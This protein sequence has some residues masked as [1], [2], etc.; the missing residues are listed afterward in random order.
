MANVK[1]YIDYWNLQLAWN[2]HMSPNKP[3]P[4]NPAIR[5]A[6]QN[7]PTV[8]LSE[9]PKIFGPGM[10][11]TH[12]GTQV[13]A[14][15]QPQGHAGK[16]PAAF[17]TWLRS[18][19]GQMTGFRISV[20][21]RKPKK[22]DCPLCKKPIHRTVEKGVDTS[23]VTDLFAGALNDSYDIAILFSNDS[24]F[25]PAIATIQDRLNKQIIHAGFNM[26]ADAVRT[27]AWGHIV[28]DGTVADSL[29]QAAV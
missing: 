6:W 27:A 17:R 9:L 3:T 22:D 28:L 5:L 10:P 1:I 24:D 26:G 23:I 4:E 21:E 13:Y 14:S 12:K 16:E 19:L 2:R 11:L 20:H 18:G 8:L 29:K 15:V 25:V 7:L